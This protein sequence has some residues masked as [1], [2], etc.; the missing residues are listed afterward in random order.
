MDSG[1]I[2][3][4]IPSETPEE[5]F[6]R[7]RQEARLAMEG[8]ERTEKRERGEREVESQTEQATLERQ[9]SEIATQKEKLELDWVAL[10]DQQKIIQ[11]TLTPIL[12][13]EKTA[14]EEEA[15]LEIEEAKTG[16]TQP[17]VEVEKKRW[18]T[19]AKRRAAEEEKWGLQEK[20]FKIQQAIE[21]NTQKYR[22]L[23]DQEETA[24]TKLNALRATSSNT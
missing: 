14:E 24:R 12:E 1:Q 13:R 16:L 19:Q 21:N 11:T 17:K 9:L 8:P 4:D 6:E 15:R 3:T 10:D 22:G 7:K 20:L 2:K 18:A 5:L 23:L